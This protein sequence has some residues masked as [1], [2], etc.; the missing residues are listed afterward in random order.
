MVN[1]TSV[2][3]V[4]FSF[5]FMLVPLYT[6]RRFR[7]SG[8]HRTCRCKRREAGSGPVQKAVLDARLQPPARGPIQPETEAPL[9]TCNRPGRGGQDCRSAE[10]PAFYSHAP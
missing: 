3:N 6:A 8:G 10:R 4:I 1:S 9:S 5:A 7:S 2:L